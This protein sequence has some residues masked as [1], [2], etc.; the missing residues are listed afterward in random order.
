MSLHFRISDFCIDP[1]PIPQ[2]IADKILLHHIEPAEKTR[3]ML[4]Q[5]IWPSQKSGYRSFEHE[6]ENGRSGYSEHCFMKMGAV[7]WTTHKEHIERLIQILRESSPYTRVCYYPNN[8]F[9]H[10]DYKARKKQF[11]ICEDGV[12]WIRQ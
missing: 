1:G 12:N 3:V 2:D 5:P 10:C 8:N 7:D 9:I 6:K 11:F 4:G